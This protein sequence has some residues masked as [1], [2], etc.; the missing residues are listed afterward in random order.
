MIIIESVQRNEKR[1][2]KQWHNGQNTIIQIDSG[3]TSA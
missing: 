1:R 3:I 2:K